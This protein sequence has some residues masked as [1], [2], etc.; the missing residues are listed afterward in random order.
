MAS[1]P[2]S[3]PRLRWGHPGHLY[4]HCKLWI[5][6][7]PNHLCR[8]SSPSSWW[9]RSIFRPVSS[10]GTILWLSA[11]ELTVLLIEG[12]KEREWLQGTEGNSSEPRRE[13]K[14]TRGCGNRAEVL[15]GEVLTPSSLGHHSQGVAPS[16]GGLSPARS[17]MN[18]GSPRVS[19]ATCVVVSVKCQLESRV[20]SKMVF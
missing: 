3:C 4:P 15:C 10:R 19:K 5:L 12:T 2:R 8:K 14:S 20:T 7:A 6:F 9:L 11:L 16:P 13:V 18:D 1:K 17:M